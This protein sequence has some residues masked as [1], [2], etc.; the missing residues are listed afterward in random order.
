MP[1]AKILKKYWGYDNFRPLQEDI[2][3]AVLAGDVIH[4]RLCLQEVANLFVSRCPRWQKRG[5]AS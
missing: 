5:F 2:I 1:E 4:W 3:R